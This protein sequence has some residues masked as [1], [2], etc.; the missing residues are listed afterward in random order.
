M[1][2]T[3]ADRI[4]FIDENQTRRVFACLLEHV[5]N[6]AGA[7]ANEH[8]DKI[9]TADAEKRRIRFAGNCLGE[10][11]FSGSWRANH[12]YALWNTPTQSLEFFR[13]LQKLDEFRN[14]FNSLFNPRNILEGC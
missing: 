4:N 10:K 7:Y 5:S 1:S 8:F 6:A 13:V 3:P 12:Q 14:L 9:R 11:G 2:T